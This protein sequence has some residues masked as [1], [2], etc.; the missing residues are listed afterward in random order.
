MRLPRNWVEVALG[1]LGV[2]RGGGTPSKQNPR[3]WTSGTIPWV[4]PKDMKSD[5]ITGAQDLI[6][7]AAIDDGAVSIVPA[8]S[9][10]IVTRSGI[11]AHSVPVG[12]T[13]I[14]VA[15]NQDIKAL[16][17]HA[18]VDA[19]FVAEQIRALAPEVLAH[20]GKAG[21]TVESLTLDRL[22]TF[23]IR[24]A[25]REEQVVIGREVRHLRARIAR[26]Q[27]A[28]QLVPDGIAS[29]AERIA[30]MLVAGN[31]SA[32]GVEARERVATAT[33]QELLVQPAR[34][35][36][37]IRGSIDPPGVRALRLGALRSPIVDLTDVRYLPIEE[38]ATTN[39]KI[40]VGDVLISRGSGT[41]RFVARAA[42]VPIVNEHTLFPDTAYR[43][44]FDLDRVVPEWFVAVWN[45]PATRADFEARVRTTA[46]IWKVAWRDLRD[47]RI[48]LPSVE[49]QRD[50]VD[51]LRA[52]T[53]RLNR[54]AAKRSA[55]LRTLNR[56]EVAMTTRAF[57]GELI[58]PIVGD[59]A[60]EKLLANLIA[61]PNKTLGKSGR[62][63]L[64]KKAPK[65]DE[66]LVSWP[67]TGR[68][69]EQL[70][71]LLPA[72]YEDAKTALFIALE[73]GVLKQRYDTTLDAM[74]FVRPS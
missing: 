39:Y 37:S 69:F 23:K 40:Q 10:L 26:A 17:P 20:A 3:Y 68:T 58:G 11:L 27:Y 50:A 21:T 15:I 2:W 22:K 1:D 33:V 6:T 56:Y 25:P 35:G 36:L 44:R 49:E 72:T 7:Q 29:I 55:A 67:T 43:L 63:K 41:K 61:S 19:T 51:A 64:A 54:A 65:L 47:V 34:T 24:L 53:A 9:I 14:D 66:L 5:V 74:I 16:V 32:S 4:S 71:K 42:L 18:G 70:R 13:L 60:P 31:L 12:V 62:Q 59:E 28:A 38:G 46:G 57:D 30:N 52:A 73:T 48:A 8:G 45:A